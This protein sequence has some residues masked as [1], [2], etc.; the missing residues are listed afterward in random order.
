MGA[1]PCSHGV[2]GMS[3]TVLVWPQKASLQVSNVPLPIVT[4]FQR[5]HH[6]PSLILGIP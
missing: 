2:H 3:Y 1:R 4:D 5:I 6:H